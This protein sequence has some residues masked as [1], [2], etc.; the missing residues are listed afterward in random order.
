MAVERIEET[1]LR[2]LLFNEEYYRKV[3]PFLKAEYFNEYHER[4]LFEEVADF[5]SKY[6]KVPT[7]EVL[8]INLQSRNDLT[9]DTF[10]SSLSTLKSLGDEWVDF[11]WL[12]DST[13]KWC[14]DRAIYLALMQSIKIAD[15]GDKKLS[16]DA[17]PGILQEALAVSFDEHIGHDYIEQAEARYEFYHRTEEKI[18]FDLEKFNFITK[19]GLP[20]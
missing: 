4:I 7:Q 9:E 2:N 11:N 19:G 18:P 17:I 12:L 10:Q 15:G 6:D 5:A 1:I 3:V 8:S 13:E 14:Q 16:K 20:N